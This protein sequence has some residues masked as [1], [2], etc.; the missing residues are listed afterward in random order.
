MG[1]IMFRATVK[2]GAMDDLEA[3]AQR[4]FA[5]IGEAAPEEVRYTA[6]RVAG[7]DEVVGLLEVEDRD[8]NPLSAVPEFVEW[9]QVVQRSIAG[10]PE[11]TDLEPM[12]SYGLV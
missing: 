9:Q 8:A 3:A 6:M 11:I 4:T 10:P 7:S 2:P 1:L 12:G 5:A